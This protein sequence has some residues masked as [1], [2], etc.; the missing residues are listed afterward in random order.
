MSFDPLVVLV[1]IMLDYPL[2][3]LGIVFVVFVNMMLQAFYQEVLAQFFRKQLELAQFFN[4]Y[5]ELSQD[6][7]KSSHGRGRKLNSF[8]H[9]GKAL[10]LDLVSTV[11]RLCNDVAFEPMKVNPPVYPAFDFWGESK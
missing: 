1:S 3:L 11:S 6:E 2:G 10:L 4:T 7:F 9:S 5:L 8:A